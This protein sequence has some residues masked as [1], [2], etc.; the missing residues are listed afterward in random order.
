MSHEIARVRVRTP[1]KHIVAFA[2]AAA[3]MVAGT[4][5]LV[6]AVGGREAPVA[7]T[8]AAVET[9]GD[10]VALGEFLVDLAPDRTGRAA[11]LKLGASASAGGV[12]AREIERRQDE[13]RERLT[14][15]LRGLSRDDIAGEE[16]MRLLKEEMLRR[17]NLVIAPQAVADVTITDIIVQ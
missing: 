3:V 5:A 4:V 9:G 17:V 10:T 11:Y 13:I 8:A 12:S 2:T 16:G 6:N 1:G 15:L 14:F 7:A